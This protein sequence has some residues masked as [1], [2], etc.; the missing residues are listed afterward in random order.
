MLFNF[1]QDSLV[2]YQV[3]YNHIN[4]KMN[5]QQLQSFLFK[6]LMFIFAAKEIYQHIFY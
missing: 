4:N 6:L 1:L 5:M 3:G 2:N